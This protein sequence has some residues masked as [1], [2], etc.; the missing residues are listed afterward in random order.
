MA[1][2][3]SNVGAAAS[4]AASSRLAALDATSFLPWVEKYRPSS[5]TDLISQADIVNTSECASPPARPRLLAGW[6][7][8]ACKAAVWRAWLAARWRGCTY[9]LAAW[10]AGEWHALP[11]WGGLREPAHAVV[12]CP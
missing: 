5:L 12:A 1:G 6:L 2:S 3:G 7:A 10:L 8:C 9:S 4:A 11:H